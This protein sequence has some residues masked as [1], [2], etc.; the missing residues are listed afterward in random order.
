MLKLNEGEGG[1]F[2]R[3]SKGNINAEPADNCVEN[4]IEPEGIWVGCPVIYVMSM[5]SDA[6]VTA[7]NGID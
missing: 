1:L 5:S 6:E 3:I 7:I 4:D 2:F